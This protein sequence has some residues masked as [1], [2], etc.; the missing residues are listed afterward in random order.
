MS[1]LLCLRLHLSFKSHENSSLPCVPFCKGLGKCSNELSDIALY[2]MDLSGASSIWKAL[3]SN[4]TSTNTLKRMKLNSTFHLE[5]ITSSCMIK[6]QWKP[7]L[8]K[9][10]LFSTQGRKS[11]S[12]DQVEVTFSL[13]KI[14][15]LISRSP[16]FPI[17]SCV[18][19]PCVENE[20]SQL[21]FCIK[22]N[23]QLRQPKQR[24][25]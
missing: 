1:I 25:E 6:K 22:Q 23:V 15:V 14:K 21:T 2:Y 16:L 13:V 12:S 7:Q 10:L 8:S 24:K 4:V 19:L 18:V 5:F 3:D 20:F 11:E 17:C 9:C